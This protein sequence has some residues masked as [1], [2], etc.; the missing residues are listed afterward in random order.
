LRDGETEGK[1]WNIGEV[2]AK[3]PHLKEKEVQDLFASY[4]GYRRIEDHLY[5]V[6]DRKFRYSLE[7]DDYETLYSPTGERLGFASS[8]I[9]TDTPIKKVWDFETRSVKEISPVY[10]Q[11]KQLL[12]YDFSDVDKK[13]RSPVIQLVKLH[14]AVKVGDNLYNYA[15]LSRNQLGPI[16][17]GSLN[18]IPGYVSRQYKEWFVVEKQPKKLEVDGNKIGEVELRQYRSAAGMEKTKVDA[19][20][21]KARFE[22]EDPNHTY[23]VRAERKDIED[24]VIFDSKIYDSYFK[25]H[26]KRGGKLPGLNRQTDIEDVLVSQTKA[27]MTMS[28]LEAF[29]SYMEHARKEFVKDYG[30]FTGYKFPESISDISARGMRLDK[31]EEAQLLAAQK[32]Y[33]Q[34]E[35][36]QYSTLLSDE[37]WKGGMGAIADAMEHS[38]LTKVASSVFREIGEKGMLPVKVAKALGSHMWLYMRPQRMWIVQPQQFLELSTISPTFLKQ[39]LND[40][41]PIFAGLLSRAKTMEKLQPYWDA[42]GRRGVKEYDAIIDALTKTGIMQAVDTNQM[43]HGIWKDT[44]E[45]LV[46]SKVTKVIQT[47]K[48]GVLLPS[49]IGRSIG[50]DPSEL[51]N[52]LILW[53]FSKN[54]WQAENPGKVW[55]TPENIAEIG[56]LT[57]RMGHGASTRAGLMPMQEGVLSMLAQ[58][59]AIPHKSFMQMLSSPDLT[60]N[61][62]AK[63]FGAR[64]FWYGK[65]GIP[66]GAALYGIMEQYMPD[67]TA[68]NLDKYTRGAS[69]YIM[70]ESLSYITGEKT[71]SF[72]SKSTATV[73]E[74]LF[75]FDAIN[76]LVDMSDGKADANHKAPFVNATASLFLAANDLWD[77]YNIPVLRGDEPDW[78]LITQKGVEFY[79]GWGSGSVKDIGKALMAEQITKTGQ[80]LGRAKTAGERINQLFGVPTAYESITWDALKV[81]GKR[82][83]FIDETAKEIHDRAMRAKINGASELKDYWKDVSAFIRTMP[84]EYHDDLVVA[85]KKWDRT[86][87]TDIGD[88][89]AIYL[90]NN[91]TTQNDGY[92]QELRNKLNSTNDPRLKQ[93]NEV[94]K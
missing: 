4:Y 29:G 82:E 35:L 51:M 36:Q 26:Q 54:K 64:M 8:K 92:M 75:V 62:R 16:Q 41:G 24:K 85:I 38:A 21:L 66:G 93:V 40:L 71:D 46:P 72:W 32:I 56:Q 12:G 61:D 78:E 19:N 33:K 86:S 53:M 50:Y 55:N 77:M 23:H 37:I 89:L 69:D 17:P 7:K 22:A 27:I 34:L 87:Q 79:L 3:Y 6:S 2:R 49:R 43:I 68:E 80:N 90:L 30:K 76:T 58:F 81:K 31:G 63:L 42:V 20:L 88:S 74:T 11:E 28:R 52:Q 57:W 67:E 73:P 60:P 45:E 18:R 39:A 10:S 14:D 70:N 84:E 25:E 15:N 1:V 47:T 59:I 48:K 83:K 13:L 65:W 91:Y 5:K 44:L 94:L 9:P